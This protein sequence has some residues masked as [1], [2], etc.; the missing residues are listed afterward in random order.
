[1]DL[2]LN[3]TSHAWL[4]PFTPHDMGHWPIANAY[5]GGPQENMPLEETGNIMIMMAA[6][7]WRDK[8]TVFVEQYWDQLELWAQYLRN[9]GLYPEKQLSSDDF[10]GPIANSTNLA[11]KS[12]IG[13]GAFALM[14]KDV[15][16]CDSST[17]TE[18][19]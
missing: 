15:E 13:L 1:M 18:Y 19:E 14:C 2:A 7:S 6:V 9:H 10:N 3:R 16:S 5:D 4:H 11:M 17:A 12:I 8:S